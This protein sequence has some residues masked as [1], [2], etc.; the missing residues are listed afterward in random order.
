MAL[1]NLHLRAIPFRYAG[2]SG[3]ELTIVALHGTPRPSWALAVAA[4]GCLI[5][6]VVALWMGRDY[7][8]RAASQKAS[9]LL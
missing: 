8:R 5:W 9:N 3:L 4:A 6:A 1:R 7:R 2:Y